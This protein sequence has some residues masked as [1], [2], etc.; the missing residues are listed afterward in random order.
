MKLNSARGDRHSGSFDRTVKLWNVATRRELATLKGH[1]EGV[2][3]VAFSTNGKTLA[4]G[5]LDNTVM[6]WDAA[7]EKQVAAQR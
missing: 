5:S 3:S 7:T 1:E 4:S 2:S 6:L